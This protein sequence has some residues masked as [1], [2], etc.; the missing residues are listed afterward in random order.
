MKYNFVKVK[1]NGGLLF[2][3]DDVIEICLICEKVFKTV[4]T[5][6]SFSGKIKLTSV[7]LKKWLVKLCFGSLAN[8]SLN[9]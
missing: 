6:L 1:S 2:L 9:H 8:K 4:M 5:Q 7:T 3:S